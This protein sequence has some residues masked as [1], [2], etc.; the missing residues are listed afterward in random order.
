MRT[1]TLVDPAG[2][3]LGEEDILKAHVEGLLH[4]AFSVYVFRNT[5][6]EILIQRRSA[7]KMLWPLAW[8]NTCCSHP[9]P[10]EAPIPAGE[11][12]LREEFGFSCSLREG[13]AFVYRAEDPSGKGIEH[14]YDMLLTGDDPTEPPAPNP[15]EIA[16]WK[17][18]ALADLRADMAAN[19]DTYAPWFHLGLDRAIAA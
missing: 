7:G 6:S 1:V 15:E 2:T 11:R 16:E 13:P 9:F 8:A 3:P 4:R 10:G 17:W 19:P 12:R 18:I 5:R 14:E